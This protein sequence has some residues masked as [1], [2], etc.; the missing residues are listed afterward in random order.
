MKKSK[1]K[2]Q[3]TFFILHIFN[4]KHQKIKNEKFFG[5][6]KNWTLNRTL[7]FRR[8]TCGI[9]SLIVHLVLVE[10]KSWMVQFSHAGCDLYRCQPIAD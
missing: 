7:P 8:L 6:K 10:H 1:K 2:Q 4:L 9:R 5:E 3:E